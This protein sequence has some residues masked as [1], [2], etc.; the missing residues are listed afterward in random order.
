[1][2]DFDISTALLSGSQPASASWRPC[3]LH[4][5]A[6]GEQSVPAAFVTMMLAV[7]FQKTCFRIP[8]LQESTCSEDSKNLG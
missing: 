1:M 7:L 2:S 6:N 3:T 8:K 5:C 4:P